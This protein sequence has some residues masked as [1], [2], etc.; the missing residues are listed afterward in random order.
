MWFLCWII[1]SVIFLIGYVFGV[2][3]SEGK[4]ADEYIEKLRKEDRK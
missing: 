4:K 1:V 2:L 3:M